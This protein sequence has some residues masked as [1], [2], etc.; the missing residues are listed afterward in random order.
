MVDQ[1]PHLTHDALGPCELITQTAPRSV[2]PWLHRWPQTVPILYS[3][4]PVSPSTL[5]LP[6][7]HLNPM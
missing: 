6:L 1:D 5:P 4:S 2:Q 7:G 3:G